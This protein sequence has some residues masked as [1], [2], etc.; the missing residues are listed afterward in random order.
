MERTSPLT[1]GKVV[2]QNDVCQLIQYTPT[3]EQVL[4]RPLL[5]VPPWINKYYILDLNPEKSFI[6]WAVEQGHTV[7][8]ISW[9]NPDEKQAEKNF[10]HYMK[11]GILASLERIR[12][13]TQQ[14]TINAIGYCVGGTLLATALAYLAKTGEADRIASTTFLA[15]QVDFTYAGDLK[16]F[17]DE[18]QI[19]I[20]EDRMN[21]KGYLDGSK[22][23]TAFNMLRSKRFDLALCREQLF[24]W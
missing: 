2:E 14:S 12:K 22:M 18:E 11:E 8:V 5:I 24:T 19:R 1:P 4:K 16:V 6:R 13:T 10:E 21:R 7:F 17:V 15:T 3:T 20:L 23:A 9:V